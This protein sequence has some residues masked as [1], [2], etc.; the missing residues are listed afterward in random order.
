[1]ANYESISSIIGARLNQETGEFE[2]VPERWPENWYRRDTEYGAVAALTDLFTE[3]YPQYLLPM[4]LPQIGSDNLNAATVLCNVQMGLGSITPLALG[5][6]EV[7]IEAGVT[8]ALGKL[9]PL[10]INSTILGC[11]TKSISPN[12]LTSNE[13]VEGGP[14]N[15]PPSVVKNTGNNVYNNVYFTETPSSP[16]QCS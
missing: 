4:P 8:W 9:A 2:Y 13:T 16:P 11:D 1:M 15:P 12:F 5:G 14:L 6:Q 7:S 3:I 10:G